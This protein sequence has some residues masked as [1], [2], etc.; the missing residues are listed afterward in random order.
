MEIS[1]LPIHA[2]SIRACAT[3][4][5]PSSATAMF[6]G[7]PISLAF[8]SAALMTRRASSNFTAVMGSVTPD[9]CCSLLD[10][11]CG[12][13]RVRKHRHVAGGN[14]D[15]SSLH[16]RRFGL[17]KLWRNSPVVARNHAPRWLRLPRGG[18]DCG[19]KNGCCRR[20]L[21]RRQYLL[22]LVC[23]ILREIF[24]DSLWGHRKKAFSVRPDFA[25]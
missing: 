19:P 24:S 11:V 20:S 13:F 12:F 18:R 1:M 23:Q 7:W 2:L 9:F 21:R 3:M 14:G 8:F 22:L 16:R 4:F 6:M 25:S 5:P 15:R 17:L 10:W